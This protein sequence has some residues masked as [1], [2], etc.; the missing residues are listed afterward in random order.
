MN[1]SEFIDLADETI[2]AIQDAL[3]EC[4]ADIDYDEINGVLTLEFENGS[5]IIFSNQAPA[6]QLWMA[7]K[8]GGFHFDYDEASQRW[9]CD[10][11]DNEDLH[12]ML[13]RLSSEQAGESVVI[14]SV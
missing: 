10:S 5:Q 2:E 11:G 12:A 3:D 4:D 7:A 13:N 14:F 8:A 6:K 9:L 1:E